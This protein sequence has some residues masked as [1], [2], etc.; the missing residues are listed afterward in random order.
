MRSILVRLFGGDATAPDLVVERRLYEF[1]R[2]IPLFNVA[3]VIATA[4][5]ILSVHPEH[6]PYFGVTYLFY[7]GFAGMQAHEWRMTDI[8][9]LGWREKRALLARTGILSAL[10]SAVCAI[11]ALALFALAETSQ[12]YLLIGWVSLCGVGG[13]MTVAADRNLARHILALCIGPLAWRLILE[14]DATMTAMACLLGMGAII[15]AQILAR[16][17]DL[18]YEVCAEK[19][20]NLAAAERARETLRGF[21]KMASDWAW[22]TDADHRLIY[23]SPNISDLTGETPQD[24][25]GRHISDVFT[26]NFYAGPPHERAE[27]RAAL[28]ERRD[29]RNLSYQVRDFSGAIRTI[30]SSMRHHYDENGHYLGVRG[31][32]TDL[33]ERVEQRRRIEESEKRFQDFAESAS[34]WLWEADSELRYTYFSE[35]ADEITG[36]KHA[37][38]IGRQIGMLEGAVKYG[39]VR[40]YPN[41]LARREAFKDAVTELIRADGS[42]VWIARSGKPVFSDEGEFLGYRG[43]GRDV[44]AEM[45]AR[46]EAERARAEL[47][48]ANARLEEDVAHRTGELTE[49]NELLDEVIES[50]ADGI[51][52]FDEDF[53]IETVNT[54]AAAMSGLPP[55]VWSVGRNITEILD[56][57]IRHGL[58]PYPT[59]DAYFEDMLRA[60]GAVGYFSTL[61][62]QKDG[63]IVSEKIRRRPCGGYVVTYAD[64][65]EMKERE[66]ALETL[67][68]ELHT[69]KEAAEAANQAKSAFLANM[70]HEIRT[71]M[72]G[73]VGMS[74]LLL[75]TALTPRQREMVQ[76]IVNSGE[77]LLTIIN[78]ILDFSKLDAGKMKMAAEPFDLRS[79]IEDVLA[80]LNLSVQK[81]GLELMLRYE[82]AL[83]AGFIG[84]PGRIRQIVTNLLGNA[85]KFTEAGHILV[86]VAGRRRGEIADI[87]ITVE[88]TG[89]GIPQDKLDTIFDAFE[90]ADNSS[91]RRHDGTGLGLA[92]T[93]KLVEAM[94][95]EISAASDVGIG[96]R[97]IVRLP[98]A[99]DAKA[100]AVKPSADDLTGVCALIVDDIKVNLDILSEQLSAWGVSSVAFGDPADALSAARKAARDGAP[101]DLAILDQQMP[102]LDGL[103]LASRLRADTLTR[104][105]PLILLTSAGRQGQADFDSALFDAYLVKPARASMLLDA[106][107]ASLSGRAASRAKE[108]YDEMAAAIG[109]P[110]YGATSDQALNVLVAEDNIVNQMVIR[111]M[112]EKLGCR[113]TIVSNGR[114]AVAQCAAQ[115]FDVIFMDIS[116]PEM[117][118][119]EATAQIRALHQPAGGKTPIIGVTAHALAGDRQRCIDAGMDDYLPKPVKPDALRRK[120]KKWAAPS[121]AARRI[122]R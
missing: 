64:I 55:A 37:D 13:A 68:A 50:M 42:T 72:N 38:F 53:I 82:P 57:G 97:F 98:L 114:E 88:D 122:A 56:I 49:R 5:L 41:A 99:I 80:L 86:S 111:S 120:L 46:R 94:G 121:P 18:V 54:K 40:E 89:C 27:L 28:A 75:D 109:A 45:T 34:D 12:K 26:E 15:A 107:V 69:A 1:K 119:V 74:S 62:K 83:G 17:H 102:N 35:R 78:D 101:F 112:L 20:E 60:L 16:Q 70:S 66:E 90:Q 39:A 29:I 32:T 96:S 19:T 104:S 7:V 95:G 33:T 117:D 93:R 6:L 2:L 36:L 59:R 67:N 23:M 81:K 105:T 76:V 31:W 85:V 110:A 92:I 43:V 3:N 63:K 44:T 73:V 65:T 91:A 118:G 47:I 113:T 25:V 9:A 100:V 79:A 116:M 61:R 106:I 58:Y 4:F 22:E 10:Q 87:E 77:N 51:V 115:N 52:V 30:S 14:G 21:M 8:A 24:I 108:T 48:E 103:E 71:P 11:V 84:D